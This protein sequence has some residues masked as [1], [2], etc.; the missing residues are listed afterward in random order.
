[1]SMNDDLC[2]VCADP[3][4]F[5]A[6][7][8]CGHKEV[9]SRCV[10]RMRFVLKDRG[11]VFCRQ[12]NVQAYFTRFM[13]DYTARLAPEEFDQLQARADRRELFVLPEI[14]GYFDDQ[15]HFQEIRALC[16]F[17]HP[18]LESGGTKSTPKFNS[19]TALKRHVEA[20]FSQ[21]FCDVCLKGR[22]VF[23]SEQLLYSKDTLRRHQE[24]GD[25]SGPLADS[26]FKGHPL[27]KFCRTR[28]YDSNELYRH[29]EGSHE[30]CF[31][32]RRAAP[33]KYVYYRHYEELEDH[34]TKDHHPCPHPACL[35][36]KFVVFSTEY[37]LKA[38]F[39]SEH[40]DE[41]K[42]SAAQRRQ[43]LT[44]PL[45]LQYRSRDDEDTE[46]GPSARLER[47][48]IIIGGGHNV[49]SRAARSGRAA[50]SGMHHSRSEPQI[51]QVAS[52]T[53]GQEGASE[54]SSLTFTAE[55]FPAP[56]SSQQSAIGAMGRWAAFTGTQA[57]TGSLSEQ[58]FPALPT[59]SKNQRRRIKDQQRTLAERLSAAAQ[60]PRVL[61]RALPGSGGGNGAAGA[62]QSGAV[63]SFGQALPGTAD[64]PALRS[65]QSVSSTASAPSSQPVL[66]QAQLPSSSSL[67]PRAV[68][69]ACPTPVIRSPPG[70][71]QDE[72]PALGGGTTARQAPLSVP[73]AYSDAA[74]GSTAAAVGPSLTQAAVLNNLFLRPGSAAVTTSMTTPAPGV[75]PDAPVQLKAEDFPSLPGTSSKAV[76]KAR[77]FKNSPKASSVKA[78]ISCHN[79]VPDK[80][81]GPAAAKSGGGGV[82]D[83]LKAANKAL[84][85]RIKRQ[86]TGAAFDTFRQQ[87]MLFMREELKAE[88]YHDYMVKLGLL[89]L[90]SELVSLCP[91]PTKRRLLLDVHRDFI[92]SPAAQDPSL[93][94]AGW[95]PPEAA[96]AK[97]NRVAQHSAWSCHR[98]SLCNAPDDSRCEACGSSRPKDEEQ[99]EAATST[100]AVEPAAPGHATR[101]SVAGPQRPLQRS[102]DADD[103]PPLLS[104]AARHGSTAAGDRR[105][106]VMEEGGPEV[107]AASPSA[108]ATSKGKKGKGSTIKIGL[109]TSGASGSSGGQTHPQNVWTQPAFKAKVANSWS[110]QGAG[111]LAKM[112]GAISD[113]WD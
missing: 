76:G 44:I 5:T 42:M 63:G 66:Q 43:A 93:A 88:E 25:E 3:L 32:C 59:L 75:A 107:V 35:E 40:G 26:G 49:S 29:M 105:E 101:G 78:E 45:Q 48:A 106:I 69:V 51:S 61:N 99:L 112:H 53:P 84:I 15:K 47:A 98:C 79:P 13:G 8:S 71:G 95:M 60:P 55:D 111:K 28:F 4:E 21:F 24:S 108:N 54:V 87:S 37:E 92:C 17:T 52:V 38:H 33:D 19:F 18:I 65:S 11:C 73:S 9:C 74:M 68:D 12:E 41:V 31:L 16:G 30:H 56:S 39:A 22:K 94:G 57:S 20:A 91:D 58:D 23:V 64:F 109:H 82:S 102:P 100:V 70:F 7:G 90:V 36:R 86:L 83:R 77:V 50:V 85:E 6:F 89:S 96:V 67:V 113:A 104:K 80:L 2:L 10:A 14:S 110:G 72:F 81:S 34:F 1:M 97:A 27:C 62:V 103:F 46:L